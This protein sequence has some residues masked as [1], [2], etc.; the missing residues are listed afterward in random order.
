MKYFEDEDSFERNLLSGPSLLLLFSLLVTWR[1]H[2]ASQSFVRSTF[3]R[4]S[5]SSRRKTWNFA[6]QLIA[7]ELLYTYREPTK[8][9]NKNREFEEGFSDYLT[10]EPS[11]FEYTYLYAWGFMN[12]EGIGTQ[13]H[14]QCCT[15]ENRDASLYSLPSPFRT[16]LY[17]MI[18]GFWKPWEG[19]D[20]S[21]YMHYWCYLVHFV[22]VD[23]FCNCAMLFIENVN[24]WVAP[25]V[26]KI[27]PA[28]CWRTTRNPLDALWDSM[29]RGHWHYY[30]C[31]RSDDTRDASCS[32]LWIQIDSTKKA[33]LP[34]TTAELK[35]K[36]MK[37]MRAT[38]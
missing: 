10:V 20:P 30:C 8:L 32:R 13:V 17:G 25:Y 33:V 2:S 37:C 15:T 21:M 4:L 38:K 1:L 22:R 11:R 31:S 26:W 3:S 19:F 24:R 28:E 16:F 7:F 27:F 36:H 18:V 9:H 29:R 14:L 5:V 35:G 23:G 12:R 6:I 34:N